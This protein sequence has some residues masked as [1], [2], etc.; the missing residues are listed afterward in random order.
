[1]LPALLDTNVSD[2]Q[3]GLMICSVVQP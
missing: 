2:G 1:M 3:E